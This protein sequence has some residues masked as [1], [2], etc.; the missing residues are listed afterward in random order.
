MRDLKSVYQTVCKES[1]EDALDKLDAKWGAY[2]IVIKSWRDN[3]EHLTEYFQYT[4]P[5]RKLIYTT[6]TV[7]GYHRQVRKIKQGCVHK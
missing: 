5:I 7:E 3:W 6:N 4:A 1:V 2:L